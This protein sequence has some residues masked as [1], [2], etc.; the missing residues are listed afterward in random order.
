MCEKIWTHSFRRD[1]QTCEQSSRSL[2]VQCTILAIVKYLVELVGF[3]RADF[4]LSPF[5]ASAALLRN[6]LRGSQNLLTVRNKTSG[7]PFP[8]GKTRFGKAPHKKV[9]LS[10][11]AWCRSCWFFSRV[12]V[13]VTRSLWAA[14]WTPTERRNEDDCVGRPAA[15]T[16]RRLD[17]PRWERR[18]LRSVQRGHLAAAEPN[19]TLAHGEQWVAWISHAWFALVYFMQSAQC[20]LNQQSQPVSSSYRH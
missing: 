3:S 8:E 17:E 1:W 13:R 19:S 18:G 10:G 7:E 4:S 6:N 2:S 16:W 20:L 5:E 9:E 12:P 11:F 14:R 15:P